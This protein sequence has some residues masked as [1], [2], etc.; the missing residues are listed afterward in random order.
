V[1]EIILLSEQ[2]AQTLQAR[3]I[4][5]DWY[6][7]LLNVVRVVARSYQNYQLATKLVMLLRTEKPS[8]ELQQLE[9]RLR[10][11]SYLLY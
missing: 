5:F 8:T 11:C 10:L 9:F 6:G 7:T 2:Q 3:G 1:F 4:N